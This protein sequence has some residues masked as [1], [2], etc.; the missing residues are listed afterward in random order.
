M[1]GGGDKHAPVELLPVLRRLQELPIRWRVVV[2]EVGL[3]GLVLLVELGEVGY[4]VLDNVHC[5]P[6]R[7][8]LS[9]RCPGIAWWHAH[10]LWGRG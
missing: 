1:W 3:D 8:V 6:Q 5:T 2:L 9:E 10:V 7:D 4:K